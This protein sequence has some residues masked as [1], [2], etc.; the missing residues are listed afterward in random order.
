MRLFSKLFSLGSVMVLMACGG[1]SPTSPDTFQPPE[2]TYRSV[3]SPVKGTGVAGIS[4][5]PVANASGTLDVIIKVRVEGARASSTYL[6]QRSPEV[7]RASGQDGVCQRAL[8]QSPWSASDPPAPAFVTFPLP[9]SGPL[10]SL[11][12]QPNGNGSLDF[13]FTST[14]IAAGTSF[15]V[16]FRLV[17]DGAAPSSELRSECLTVTAR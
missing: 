4:V 2:G 17:D 13:E 6:V 5:T 12:T 1:D 14:G 10:V 8:G 11:Q 16:M 7:G 9:S 3:L 15:D